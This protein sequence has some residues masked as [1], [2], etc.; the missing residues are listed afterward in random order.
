M[1]LR[2]TIEESIRKG[3]REIWGC[4]VQRDIDAT[5][6]LLDWYARRSFVVSEPDHDSMEGAVK[7]ISMKLETVGQHSVDDKRCSSHH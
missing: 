3:I 6:S 2:R 1:M 5:P 4:V 7:K